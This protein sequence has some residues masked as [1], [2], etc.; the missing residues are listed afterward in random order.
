MQIVTIAMKLKDTSSLEEKLWQTYTDTHMVPV[1]TPPHALRL[2]TPQ[3][4]TSSYQRG[5]TNHSPSGGAEG[6]YYCKPLPG[7]PSVSVSAMGRPFWWPQRIE[8]W[9]LQWT[10]SAHTCA[11]AQPH[12]D[13]R[14]L[15]K[16]RLP[17]DLRDACLGNH[18]LIVGFSHLVPIS[19]HPLDLCP[20]DLLSHPSN[21]RT[22]FH[23]SV[24]S[25]YLVS[26]SSSIDSVRPPGL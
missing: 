6:A 25:K 15:G 26:Q 13:S 8:R 21:H 24:K 11:S 9:G 23:P 19:L 20:P 12:S 10:T 18:V 1:P 16:P 17:G 4:G 2:P 5:G 22:C 14:G 7:G 3:S